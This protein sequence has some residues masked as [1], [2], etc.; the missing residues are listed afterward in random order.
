MAPGKKRSTAEDEPE[1]PAKR[2]KL[3][4]TDV[5]TVLVGEEKNEF[6]LHASIATKHSKFFKAAC[7][8][9]FREAQDKVT[10][11]PE[12]SPATFRAYVQWIYSGTV[13]VMDSEE[14]RS[15]YKGDQTSERQMRLMKLYVLADVLLDT[16]LRN[17]VIDEY[18]Q[19]CRSAGGAGP[20][21]IGLVYEH[22]PAGS[23]MRKLLLDENAYNIRERTSWL[24]ECRDQFN[25]DF[26][27]DLVIAISKGHTKGS[28]ENPW[29]SQPCRYHEHDDEFP[30]CNGREK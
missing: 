12:V 22:T 17:K 15:D 13:V 16:L 18:L 5:F 29:T 25:I 1:Q 30:R 21:T 27:R 4:Y 8:G 11:L 14:L 24:E 28:A 2:T 19:C 9:G 23:T 3:E 6:M 26:L 20:V 10:H 7:N